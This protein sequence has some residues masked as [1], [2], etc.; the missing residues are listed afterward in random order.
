M[1]QAQSSVA[2][3][4]TWHKTGTHGFKS[5]GLSMRL[6]SANFR[7]F[8]AFPMSL[9]HLERGLLHSATAL[10]HTFACTNHSPD[11]RNPHS[12]CELPRSN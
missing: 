12:S 9:L 7:V 11:A 2:E 10:K 1:L 4:F 6:T 5:L 8:F 3:L